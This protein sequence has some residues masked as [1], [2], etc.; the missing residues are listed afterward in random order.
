LP[1]SKHQQVEGLPFTETHKRTK[2]LHKT[3]T[4]TNGFW[5]AMATTHLSL[6]CPRENKPTAQSKY[7]ISR[8]HKFV[9]L[10]IF[11]QDHMISYRQE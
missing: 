5:I 8:N 3:I 6:L 4:Q 2:V 7:I 1:E 10:V 11:A 9:D